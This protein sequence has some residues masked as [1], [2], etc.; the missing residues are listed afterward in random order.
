LASWP[1]PTMM[2]I[3]V[4]LHPRFLFIQHIQMKQMLPNAACVCSWP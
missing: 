2:F 4:L 1:H 3:Q